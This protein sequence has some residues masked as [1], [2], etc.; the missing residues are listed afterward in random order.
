MA[1]DVGVANI[2]AKL[3]WQ[4]PLDIYVLQESLLELVRRHAFL[5]TIIEST[6]AGLTQVTLA[7]RAVSIQLVDLRELSGSELQSELPRRLSAAAATPIAADQFP[8]LRATAI[9]VSA[10]VTEVVFAVSHLVCDGVSM[11]ILCREL[12]QAYQSIRGGH[13]LKWRVHPAGTPIRMVP[14][15]VEN[16]RQLN[17]H[18]S[19]CRLPPDRVPPPTVTYRG[20]QLE[21]QITADQ[22]KQISDLSRQHSVS[23]FVTWL[24]LL[25]SVM[26]RY[27]QTDQMVIDIAESG[28]TSESRRLVGPFLQTNPLEISA[29][30]A[31]TFAN[32]LVANHQ[33]VRASVERSRTAGT[34]S[35]STGR[36]PLILLDYQTGIEPMSV[37]DDVLVIPAEFDNGA[38]IAAFCLGVRRT[39]AGF[40]GHIKFDCDL[41]SNEMAARFLE[42]FRQLVSQVIKAPDI[43]L[44]TIPLA[45]DEELKMLERINATEVEFDQTN[46]VDELFDRRVEREP[47]APAVTV[48]GHSHSY[49]QVS[50]L[51]HQIAATLRRRGMAGDDRVAILLRVWSHPCWEFSVP[52]PPMY[53]LIHTV[54]RSASNWSSTMPTSGVL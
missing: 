48:H 34:R 43:P 33:R 28:R 30:P 50:W 40:H 51:S 19:D 54:P 53:P 21:F 42:H 29:E 32:L 38:A 52:V 23:P 14:L 18:V 41:F 12:V 24:S 36:R 17:G 6:P 25:E 5:R 22:S 15:P 10:D 4:G 8:W 46:L 44:S 3:R 20:R 45:I 9:R 47:N 31:A 1:P 39:R 35:Q 16:G 7:P 49:A 37:D 11:G 2:A 26:L 27:T 13:R